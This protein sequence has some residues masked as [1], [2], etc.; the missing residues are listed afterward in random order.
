MSV[1]ME[2]YNLPDPSNDG[3]VLIENLNSL[4]IESSHRSTQYQ[5][6]IQDCIDLV[7]L[8]LSGSKPYPCLK[9]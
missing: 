2:D 5:Q 8:F 4:L 1:S 9:G 3:S 7:T 6:G